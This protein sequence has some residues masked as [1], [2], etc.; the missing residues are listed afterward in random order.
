MRRIL[1]THVPL[2]N[3]PA[4]NFQPYCR[5]VGQRDAGDVRKDAGEALKS[6][7]ET[8][9]PSFLNRGKGMSTLTDINV[10][11]YTAFILE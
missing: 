2:T 11:V 6:I 1:Q 10:L 5:P 3:N 4:A 9:L 7:M 8:G